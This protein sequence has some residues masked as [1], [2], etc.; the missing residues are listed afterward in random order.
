MSQPPGG[1]SELFAKLAGSDGSD[2][3]PPKKIAFSWYCMFIHLLLTMSLATF[4]PGAGTY[5]G[6][7]VV[8]PYLVFMYQVVP[9]SKVAAY[10]KS[11][12][13]G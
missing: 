6:A 3:K 1:G 8:V 9:P 11:G 13:L 4:A 7:S 2:S 12:N 10:S 5:T